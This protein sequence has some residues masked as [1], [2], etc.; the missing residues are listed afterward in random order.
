MKHIKVLTKKGVVKIGDEGNPDVVG[1]CGPEATDFADCDATSWDWCN[2][3]NYV[4]CTHYATDY[5][6]VDGCYED[7]PA[8]CHY[9]S[10]DDCTYDHSGCSFGG[11][12]IC[13]IDCSSHEYE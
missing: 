11:S 5:C 8:T 2:Q 12:D 3:A 9:G 4:G 7:I 6:D 13:D 1:Y 10:F